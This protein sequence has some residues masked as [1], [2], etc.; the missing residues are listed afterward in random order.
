MLFIRILDF[1]RSTAER[2]IIWIVKTSFLPM[3]PG[4]NHAGSMGWFEAKV[5]CGLGPSAY[6]SSIALVRPLLS[7]I[8]PPVAFD[9]FIALRSLVVSS[10]HLLQ[11]Q[12]IPGPVLEECQRAWDD[13]I[14]SIRVTS[15]LSNSLPADRAKLLACGA[16]GVG[17]WL[18][19]LPNLI[20]QS[21]C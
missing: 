15:I 6:Q 12:L 13:A 3:S 1:R 19:A 7:Y 16:P 20:D 8:L 11:E 10:W 21:H 2:G 18:H 14:C 17:S 5:S 9:C 4:L